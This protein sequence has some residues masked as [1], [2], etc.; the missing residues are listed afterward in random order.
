M[1]KTVRGNAPDLHCHSTFSILDGLGT[2]EA[3]V[4][5]AVELGWDA[6]CLSEHGWIGSVPRFYKA[7]RAAKIKPVL[8]CEMYV[9]PHDIFGVR[10]KEVRQGSFHLTVLALSREGYENLVVW[11]NLSMQP[12][13]FYYRPR[14]SIEAMVEHA[15][16]PL[17]HN[18]ILSGCIGGE[19][20]QCLANNNGMAMAAAAFYVESMKAVFP[21]FYIELQN[22]HSRYLDDKNLVEYD[23]LIRREQ[24]VTPQLVSLAEATDTPVILTNDSHYQS[25]DQRKAHMAMI[26]SKFNA[27][28]KDD[29]HHPA[30]EYGYWMNYMRSMERI[31]DKTEKG[32]E[33]IASI[34]DIVRESEVV[35]D[36]LDR[37]SYS[38]PFSGY[39][40]P[41]SEIR[42]R[43]RS[44][45]KRLAARHPDNAL[46]RFEHELEA[47]GDFAHYLLMMSDLIKW[48]KSQG[49]L[50][51]TRGSAANSI[52]CYC[53]HIHDIDSIEYRLIFERFV[54][55]ERKK[56]PDIDIDVEKDRYD[57]F[58]EKAREY[59]EEREGE[60]Q[61][62]QMGNYGTLANRATFRM[63]ADSLGIDKEKQDEISKLL[64]Q[65]I[66][67]GLVDE[68]EDS[69]AALKE[70]Y[71]DIYELASGVFDSIKN[72]GQ[73]ACAWLL[74]THERP[75]SDWV[76]LYLI[77]SSG[78]LVTQ[79]DLN[80]LEDFGLVKGD[81]L[82]LKT[83][84]V[85][86][87]CMAMSGLDALDIEAIPLDDAAT[88]EMI[89]AGKT[90]G[91]F[92]LQGKTTRQGLQEME[93]ESV[94]DVIKA[95]AIYR[96]SITRPGYH[97]VYNRRRR[98][99]EKVTYP[100]P[101]TKEILEETYGLPIFQEQ[102]L[103]LAL[104]AG[105]TVTE[106][107]DILDAIKKAK[108]VGRGAKEMFAAIRPRYMAKAAK[109][110]GDKAE[111]VWELV[112]SF[113]G[114]GF[115]RGHATSYGRLA[116]RAAY[117]K[118]HHPQNYYAALLD[119]YPEKG[120]YIAAA[121]SDGFRI[122][123]PDINRSGYGF[124]RGDDDKSI[125]VG[126]GRIKG[127]G[128][129]ATEAVIRAQPFVSV[130]D[131]RERTSTTAVKSNTLEVLREVGALDSLGI[132]SD[133]DDT[134]QLELLS[135]VL[136]KPEAFTDTSKS[137][138]AG[139]RVSERWTH[140]GYM[141]GVEH[142]S[143]RHSVSKKFWI[144][145]VADDKL[146]QL[147][148][149]LWAR[150]KTYLLLA[151]D[152]NGI[153]FHIMANEDK[154]V[155]VEYLD[156]IVRK[157]KGNVICFDGAIRQPFEQEGPL[158][159]RMY[160]VT[161]AVREDPQVWGAEDDKTVRAFVLLSRKKR[162]MRRAA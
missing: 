112:V 117:L 21:N 74:G 77:A 52:V 5:R 55:P 40:D 33:A 43:C 146:I 30:K 152:E 83:L 107:Q 61:I 60:G 71:P 18:V 156:W 125:R 82:R 134:R 4:K 105:F 155:E 49:I 12:E 14:I 44:R 46:D 3:V 150:V 132:L 104:Q 62:V 80:G 159:F 124:T 138:H 106:S 11:N 87:R 110:Y 53:L 91:I 27:W 56:L 115:N 38:I 50:T 142:T 69:Y 26:A 32:A 9:V 31:A 137:K 24:I 51:N 147:K 97:K 94:H 36:P 41:I 64:P 39:D 84:S 75:I 35:L 66:D 149:S 25:A 151:V 22:H 47:M 85:I 128:K 13:N 6:A 90:E 34:T 114:Y 57:D 122:V 127:V 139:A 158:G 145:P 148:A 2:P 20:C 68:E 154:A 48:A 96:P 120:R 16:W 54:N 37:F 102:I 19:L 103:E 99:E 78:R 111:E 86:K 79:Y 58:M 109:V 113:Q 81:W 1:R 141:A 10:S 118:C 89:R 15:R 42:R 70:M 28:R 29:A 123:P 93:V 17:H 92:T 72:I 140:D 116:V 23:D 100:H 101:L 162:Q 153:P 108:G 95:V 157:H 160:D 131:L 65:M 59:V 73:H 7:C 67:S 144:P 161:G 135:F 126:L 8:G 133:N 143:A 136:G 119:V 129:V 76:P 45:L 121:R 88:F 130:E 98:G 63:V